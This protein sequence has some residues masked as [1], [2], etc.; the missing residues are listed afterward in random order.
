MEDL[1]INE[2][3][4]EQELAQ[5]AEDLNAARYMREQQ[6]VEMTL[7]RIADG[8]VSKSSEIA[9]LVTATKGKC[10]KTIRQLVSDEIRRSANGLLLCRDY[11]Q[12]S[13]SDQQVIVFT[14]SHWEPVIP[15][16][17][18][19]FID[20]CAER[21]GVPET[22]CKDH[23]FM[24]LL[25]ENVAFN[26]K[27]YRVRRIPVGEVWL[28]ARNGTLELKGDGSIMLREHHKD[29]MFTY[30]LSYAYDPDAKCPQWLRFLGKVLPEEEAQKVLAEFTGYCLTDN[31][32]LQKMLWLKGEGQNGK[33]VTLEIIEAL[34][35]SGNISY[36]S[37]SDLTNDAIKRA[38]I[39]GKILNVSHESGR[40][41]N[42][43]V[44]K[45]L[46]SGE[47]VTIERKYKDPREIN[48]YGKFCAAFN[49]LPRAEVTG[50]YFRRI[51]ILPY[52]IT[53]TDEERDPQLAEKLKTELPGIL[54]WVLQALPALIKRKSFT[55]SEICTKAFND[56]VMQSDN[57]R[58][59]V[60]EMCEKSASETKALEL[61]FAYKRYC[62]ES[63]L[64]P[65]GRTKFYDRMERIGVK[66][67]MYANVR[68]FNLKLVE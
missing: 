6:L 51:I 16:Q 35:G 10:D 5:K 9:S 67:S 46:A 1:I 44:L 32:Q 11:S 17:W 38:G 31:H 40:D 66:S 4:L 24:N 34:F 13:K 48:D 2:C 41:V 53:I 23:G 50:G 42:P 60:N 52:N 25:Y 68:Y 22:Q 26:V 56:Y 29:D 28:N 14:G 12:R 18:K 62:D 65:L 21:C 8:L 47:R 45:Q 15:T 20:D 57:V 30:T 39:E 33:S 36:L 54:N 58:M 7:G 3:S 55:V 49:V 19:D 43:N 59:F 64:H 63:S 27:G 61:F 37:L